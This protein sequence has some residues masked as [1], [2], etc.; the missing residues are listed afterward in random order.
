MRLKSRRLKSKRLKSKRL[1]SEL[2]RRSHLLALRV[3]PRFTD[4]IQLLLRD[5][6]RAQYRTRSRQR[7]HSQDPR[8][9]AKNNGLTLKQRSVFYYLCSRDQSNLSV[10]NSVLPVYPGSL[11]PGNQGITKEILHKDWALRG[12]NAGKDMYSAGIRKSHGPLPMAETATHEHAVSQNQEKGQRIEQPTTRHRLRR[13]V[14]SWK[15]NRW[16]SPFQAS[17]RHHQ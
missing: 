13:G 5:P 16:N 3:S 14:G 15:V 17:A 11:F 10:P 12:E 8:C 1:K 4:S 7:P 9:R 2:P 6:T